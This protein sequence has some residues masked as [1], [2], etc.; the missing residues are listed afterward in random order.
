MFRRIVIH[1]RGPI[2]S[3]RKQSLSWDIWHDKKNK[4]GLVVYCTNCG[5]EVRIPNNKFLASFK[6]KRSYPEEGEGGV[7]FSDE[8][9]KFLGGADILPS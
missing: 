4:S 2:C 8:D 3:C 6:L 9:K 7:G 5:V 1:L